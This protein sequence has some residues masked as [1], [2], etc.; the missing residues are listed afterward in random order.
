MGSPVMS[1][2]LLQ[3][4]DY[5]A[6]FIGSLLNPGSA[7]S[8]PWMFVALCVGVAFTLRKHAGPVRLAAMRRATL[9]RKIFLERVRARGLDNGPF[10][11]HHVRR[12]FRIGAHSHRGNQQSREPR[13][14][15]AYRQNAFGRERPG[16]RHRSDG[17]I[18]PELRIRLLAGPLSDAQVRSAVALPLGPPHGKSLSPLTNYRVHPSIRSSPTTSWRSRTASRPACFSS[19]SA[20]QLRPT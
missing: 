8:L 2:P 12:L 16:R 11:Q 18:L 15:A 4:A 13:T 3:L 19:C 20:A 5:L 1:Q 10:Q 14:G 17:R 6:R 9:P 7:G